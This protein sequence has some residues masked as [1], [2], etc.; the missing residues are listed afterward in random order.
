MTEENRY[1]DLDA[2]QARADKEFEDMV[3]ENNAKVDARRQKE[4]DEKQKFMNDL[5]DTAAANLEKETTHK[6]EQD[7]K[8]EKAIAM[9]AIDDKYDKQGVV[10]SDDSKNR[11][12]SYKDMLKGL[13]LVDGDKSGVTRVFGMTE[14]EYNRWLNNNGFGE[15]DTR[16]ELDKAYSNLIEKSESEKDPL[17]F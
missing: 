6:R 14:E 13:N 11:D 17:D 2:M 3:H 12:E 9:K 1:I 16:S 5:M 7:I 10:K 8:R 4:I 15:P